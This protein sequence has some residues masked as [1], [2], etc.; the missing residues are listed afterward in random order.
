EEG[1]VYEKN[2]AR[3]GCVHLTG[4]FFV[5][6][7]KTMKTIILSALVALTLFAT[8]GSRLS[9][10]FAQGTT[11]TYQGRLNDGGSPANGTNYGMLFHLYDAATGGTSLGNLGIVSVT[12]SN[13]LFTVPLDF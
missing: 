5:S 12:V 11:F 1:I 2:R 13:G 10:A 8:A 9:S 4:G 3:C 7:N 6:Q